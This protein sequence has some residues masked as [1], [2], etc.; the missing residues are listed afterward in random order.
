MIWAKISII[1][2]DK[3]LIQHKMYFNNNISHT[4]NEKKKV[5]P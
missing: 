5:Q 2:N 3:S 4:V 1:K